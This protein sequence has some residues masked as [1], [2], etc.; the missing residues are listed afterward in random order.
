MPP[1]YKKK[2]PTNL[3]LFNGDNGVDSFPDSIRKGLSYNLV[4]AREK[5]I[6]AKIVT[7]HAFH[8]S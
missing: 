2:K 7:K 6:K 5:F 3:I 8:F 4:G 1:F